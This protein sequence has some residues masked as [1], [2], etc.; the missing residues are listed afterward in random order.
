MYHLP[1]TYVKR[2]STRLYLVGGG[3]QDVTSPPDKIE[4][5]KS[6]DENVTDATTFQAAAWIGCGKRWSDPVPPDVVRARN[7]A[8][9]IPPGVAAAALPQP[10]ETISSCLQQH[11]PFSQSPLSQLNPPSVVKHLLLCCLTKKQRTVLSCTIFGAWC[12]LLCHSTWP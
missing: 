5:Y 8:R 12:H 11:L 4:V 3:S 9:A 7:N 6:N 2:T 1:Y 10:N